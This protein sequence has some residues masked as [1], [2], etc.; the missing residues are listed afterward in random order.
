MKF[1]F[2]QSLSGSIFLLLVM[3]SLTGYGQQTIRGTVSNTEQVLIPGVNITIK[4]KLKGTTTNFEGQYQ[5][6]AQAQDTLVFTYL[7]YSPQEIPV[8]NQ[9]E[10][11]TVLQEEENSL[12]DLVINAGYYKVRDR[13]RTG[14][15]AKVT[16]EEIELQPLVSPLQALQGRIAGVEISANTATP[17]GAPTIRI[18]GQNSLRKEGNYPLYIID[19]VPINSVP[20]ESNT[21]LGFVGVDP[22]STMSLS[23][24]KSIEVLKDADATA[25]YGSRGANGVIL[26]TTKTGENQKGVQARI[27]SGV[28]IIPKKLDLLNTNQYLTLRKQAF[29]NDGVEPD[30]FN[31]Y[32]LLLWDQ[33]RETDWQDYF[34]GGTAN[35]TDV[36]VSAQGGNEQTHFRLNGAFHKQ[37]TIYPVDLN[38]Q[39]FTGGF[40]L[41]HHTKDNKFQLNLAINYGIDQNELIGDGIDFLSNAFK[42]PPNAPNLY[43]EDGSLNWT[44]WGEA[45]LAHPLEG[46]FNSSTIEARNLITNLNLSYKI[47]EGLELKTNLGFTDYKS[48]ELV[49]MPKRSYNPAG[50]PLHRSLSTDSQRQT[51]IAEP[52]LNYT[53]QWDKLNI[54]ALIGSTIQENQYKNFSVEGQ[55]Y[56]AE[57]LIGNLGAAEK[58]LNAQARNID[59][60]YQAVFSRIGLNWDKKYYLNLTARRDGSSR[61]AAANRFANFGAIGAAWI[62]T[63][64]AFFT[65]RLNWLSF[66]KIRG[67]YGTTGNDQIPDYGYL[68]AYEATPGPGGLYPVGLAN[69]KYTWEK[70]KKAEIALQLGFLKDKLDVGISAYRNRS[71]NQLVGYPLPS[72]TGFNSVQ[73]N[74]P[75]TVENSGWEIEVSSENINNNK[76]RWETSFNISF[77]RNELIRYPGLEQSSYANIYKEGHPLNIRFLY[78]Y[79]GVNPETGYYS[80]KDQNGDEIYDQEDKTIIQDLTREYFGGINNTISYQGISLQFLFQFVKQQGSFSDLFNAG[81][82][83]NQIAEVTHNSSSYAQVSQTLDAFLAYANVTESNFVIEDASFIRMKTINLSYSLPVKWIQS[84]NLN[85]VKFFITGQNLFTITDYKGMDPETLQGGTDFS[86]LRTFTGGLQLNF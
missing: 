30:E 51:W 6:Q 3:L 41:N 56:V 4:N 81:F 23:N 28:S 35:I 32:D 27:Y 76:V 45:G 21:S 47:L 53:K 85:Q 54:Q 71:S 18:R 20:V 29:I 58:L 40:N 22:L 70:N 75:A 65:K 15:I 78:E 73:A 44:D 42:L 37:G 50:M 69:P 1:L 19:G 2:K 83:Q 66:G 24:I 7:G 34:L 13:E 57:A 10:I 59:Y 74:L 82:P 52:Q 26:I 11:N 72:T 36:N 86:N 14:N 48:D 5:I 46:V 38:Y 16:A 55:N 84:L 63:E 12:G 31:A 80:V 49:K 79:E 9:T 67:S 64:E 43:L 17:G 61:F 62:F 60:R 25:I 33:N 8:G 77:P 39:K 68:D